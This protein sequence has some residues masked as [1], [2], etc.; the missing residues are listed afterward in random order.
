MVKIECF[1]H[2]TKRLPQTLLTKKSIVRVDSALW[3]FITATPPFPLTAGHR[4]RRALPPDLQ[5]HTVHTVHCTALHCIALH[6]T[7]SLPLFTASLPRHAALSIPAPF[8]R[9]ALVLPGRYGQISGKSQGL[10]GTRKQNTFTVYMFHK[11]PARWRCH[12][13]TEWL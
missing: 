12:K 5:V 3:G 1:F 10:C 6:S 2:S 13:I 9:G 7:A 4:R 11:T 8:R